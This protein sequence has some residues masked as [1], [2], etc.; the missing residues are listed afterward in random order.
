[1]EDHGYAYSVLEKLSFNRVAGTEDEKKAAQ[2]LLSEI[3]QAGGKGELME[4]PI[5]ASTVTQ[6]GMRIVSPYAREVRPLRLA[7]RRRENAE[8]LLCRTRR[9]G[10]LCG[11]GRPFRYRGNGKFHFV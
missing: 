4:F 10:G 6:E 8:I 11:H 5:P 9:G 3:E 7:A 1:M 2:L